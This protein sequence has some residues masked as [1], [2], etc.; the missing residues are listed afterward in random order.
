MDFRLT[1]RARALRDE[2]D[3]FMV[4]A[5]LP[6]ESIYLE[7]RAKLQASGHPNVLPGVVEELKVQARGRGLWNL[8]LPTVSGLLN[9]EYAV[10]AEQTGWSVEIAPEALNCSAPDTGN[11]EVLERFGSPEQQARWLDP[12][13]E[14]H[15]RSAFAMTEPDVASSDATNIRTRIER[16][17][18]DYVI[19]GRKWWTT[20]VA[21]PRCAVL[22]VM[23]K[24]DPNGPKHRQQSMVLVPMDTPG[25]KVE[26]ILPV[27]G[28]RDQHGHGELS[29]TDVRVP[30]EN[31][32]G[33]EGSGFA[34][35]Q[36]RLGPGRIH[37]CMRAI[38]MAERAIALAV[39]RAQSRTVFGAVIAQQSTFQAELA[40]HRMAVEQ[41][42]LY[43][44][45][46]A[47]LIDEVGAQKARSEIAAIKVV[48]PRAV[49]AAI[50]WAIQVHGAAGVGE[51]TPL[52]EMWAYARTLRIADGPDAVHVQ[53]VARQELRSSPGTASD[54][55]LR[56]ASV[57]RL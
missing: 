19:N 36:A 25:V 14:G 30:A 47:W 42:R 29:F 6:S 3:D 45:K 39:E 38:G 18:S 28:Y 32:I 27:F 35:A 2:L 48:V 31:L 46:T 20:G 44:L 33:E 50:D 16:D 5:V 37:H 22:I 15:I 57:R 4:R 26:R 10:L 52:P 1:E 43:V 34:I 40:E 49:S 56:G 53:T 9:S 23:G 51:D 13:L 21:D 8:F 54:S 7:Q 17:G 55:N 12:L 24:S 11:M 41:A